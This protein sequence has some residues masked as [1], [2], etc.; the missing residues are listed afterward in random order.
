[1][2]E[3]VDSGSPQASRLLDTLITHLRAAVPRLHDPSTALAQELEL[4]RAYLAL[5]QLR[6][7]ERLEF[8][9][10][11]DEAA[12]SLRCPPT[13]LLTLVENAIRH[14]IDPS[15]QGGRIDVS[16]RVRG[17]RCH[18]EVRDTGMGLGGGVKGLGTGLFSLRER[19]QLVFGGDADLRL[20]AVEPHGARAT[21][22]FPAQP[23]AA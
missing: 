7:A 20:A 5:M 17:G 12:A 18:A 19:L 21:V 15:E 16:V 6:M 22:E 13:T 9:I 8:A 11:S 4:V 1:V 10:E 3:L 2:R 14:G 23:V